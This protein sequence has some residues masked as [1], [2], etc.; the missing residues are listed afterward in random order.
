MRKPRIVCTWQTCDHV[1]VYPSVQLILAW[2]SSVRLSA[3]FNRRLSA[4][5]DAFH[6]YSNSSFERH[7]RVRLMS[8]PG[9]RYAL[10]VCRSS[11][12]LDTSTVFRLLRVLCTSS[13]AV[14]SLSLRE[15]ARTGS[16]VFLSTAS[17]FFQL[18]F[19]G[20]AR[21]TLWCTGRNDVRFR[22]VLRLAKG[23]PFDRL[24]TR[25]RKSVASGVVVVVVVG[26]VMLS[27]IETL[28]FSV[29]FVVNSRSC[30]SFSVP[31]DQDRLVLR[32]DDLQR[33]RLS[34][35]KKRCLTKEGPS[36]VGGGVGPSSAAPGRSFSSMVE[37]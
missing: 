26:V 4:F 25:S 6:M 16:D 13:A 18:E 32:P 5:S 1:T 19:V 22:N 33:R 31:E 2:S 35:K 12:G 36:A 11:T 3:S 24:A 8:L 30:L 7:C 37:C 10:L 29:R 15:E 34:S 9:L 20:E 23:N 21:K 14:L 17:R 28:R 27:S